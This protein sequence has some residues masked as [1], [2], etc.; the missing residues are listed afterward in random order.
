MFIPSVQLSVTYELNKGIILSVSGIVVIRP[1]IFRRNVLSGGGIRIPEYDVIRVG[2][3][4][5]HIDLVHGHAEA[6][7]EVIS[8]DHLC[9]KSQM[10]VI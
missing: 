3:P 4:D 6:N 7:S 1:S 5:C 8:F 9:H 2:L 10:S